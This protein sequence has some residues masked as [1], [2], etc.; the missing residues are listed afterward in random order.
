MDDIENIVLTR[1]QNEFKDSLKT[2]Y[3]NLNFTSSEVSKGKPKFP[4]I[5]VHMLPSPEVGQDLEGSSI[6]G[7]FANLQVDVSDNISKQR[8]KEVMAE[9]VRIMKTM[10]FSINQMP[11]SEYRNDTYYSVIRVRRTIG[12]GE[13]I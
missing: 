8:T 7:I 2:K 9:V 4:T 11:Y 1:I 10:R 3:P 5:Y 6:N 13:T 12:A